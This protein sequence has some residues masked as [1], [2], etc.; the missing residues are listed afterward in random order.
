MTLG[1][2]RPVAEPALGDSD[3]ADGDGGDQE[4]GPGRDPG[5]AHVATAADGRG[6]RWGGQVGAGGDQGGDLPPQ[7]ILT[8]PELLLC[9]VQ[10]GPSA[11]GARASR[12]LTVPAGQPELLGDLRD[13]QVGAV[14]QDQDLPEAAAV[15]A[16]CRPR[17]PAGRLAGP[18]RPPARP[19]GPAR[20]GAGGPAAARWWPG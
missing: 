15:A 2:R 10:V 1:R 11:A 19:A 4:H 13:G 9:L 5:P 12:L 8:H 20:P 3:Q 6:R 16:A 7:L 14:V 17:W 18:P